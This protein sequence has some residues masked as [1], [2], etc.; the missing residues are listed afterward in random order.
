MTKPTKYWKCSGSGLFYRFPCRL[1]NACLAK[2]I[3]LKVIVLRTEADDLT[4][5]PDLPGSGTGGAPSNSEIAGG[6]LER[7]RRY[8][9]IAQRVE[10]G[11]PMLEWQPAVPT[12]A[13]CLN[14]RTIDVLSGE[15]TTWTLQNIDCYSRVALWLTYANL[16][17]GLT[18]DDAL[19]LLAGEPSWFHPDT[20][21]LERKLN[22]SATNRH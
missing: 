14:K 11:E 10:A 20:K 13:E 1:S 18:R 6:I 15:V 19:N 7:A 3:R 16:V 17:Y 9:K 2:F 5:T 4:K 12:E 22:E 21:F 8:E